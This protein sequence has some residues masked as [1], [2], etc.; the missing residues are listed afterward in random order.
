MKN[1]PNELRLGFRNPS[2]HSVSRI[3]FLESDLFEKWVGTFPHLEYSSPLSFQHC[4]TDLKPG[5][6]QTHRFAAV[7]A[8]APRLLHHPWATFPIS[9]S[10][11]NVNSLPLTHSS[12]LAVYGGSATSPEWAQIDFGKFYFLAS[13]ILVQKSDLT[14]T[15][16]QRPSLHWPISKCF[17]SHIRSRSVFFSHII[18]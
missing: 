14:K 9:P 5:L 17:F 15:H 2:D 12:S 6:Q 13:T 16:H 4:Y 3:E 8:S 18:S 1:L 7:F 10:E 11:W